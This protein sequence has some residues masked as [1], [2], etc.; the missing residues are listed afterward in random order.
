MRS[1][2]RLAFIRTAGCSCESVLRVKVKVKSLSRVRLFATPWTCDPVDC[3][4]PGSS[5][6]GIL[7]ARVLE[8]GSS[9]SRDRTQVSGIAGRRFT[10]LATRE[11]L[12][13][14][15]F[16]RHIEQPPV[17]SPAVCT[18]NMKMNLGIVLL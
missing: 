15:Q 4:P 10:L 16:N 6:H 3:S 1:R 12:S 17:L 11:A 9:S 5:V 13:A 18:G 14:V 2:A 8:W 7:Q